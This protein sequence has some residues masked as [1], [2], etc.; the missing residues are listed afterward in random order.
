MWMDEQSRIIH[1]RLAPLFAA[2]AGQKLKNRRASDYRVSALKQG[3][4]NRELEKQ[5]EELKAKAQKPEPVRIGDV[6]RRLGISAIPK[7]LRNEDSVVFLRKLENLSED[8]A[9]GW[10]ISE[11]G[12]DRAAATAAELIRSKFIARASTLPKLSTRSFEKIRNDI[13]AQLS[14][15]RADS[16]EVL[17]KNKTGKSAQMT[18][19]AKPKTKSINWALEDVFANL[20]IIKTLAENNVIQILPISS[21]YDYLCVEG[22]KSK[23]ELAE[24]NFDPCVLLQVRPRKFEAVL[25]CPV[26]SVD[27]QERAG[28]NEYA[29]INGLAIFA[30]DRSAAIPLVGFRAGSLDKAVENGSERAMRVDLVS[31]VDIDA[32][33]INI[34][35]GRPEHTA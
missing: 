34:I 35:S 19:L 8:E 6:A 20:P 27:T 15:L 21:N 4:R 2:V 1:K 26:E 23:K 12:E 14:A 5:L 17:Y 9:F 33:S 22:A 10:I 7:E 16:F 25:R 13:V 11:F 24:L 31:A 28:I 29:A 18:P 32:F 30:V 3:K